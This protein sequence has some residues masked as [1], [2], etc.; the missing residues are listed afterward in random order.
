MTAKDS[1]KIS[2]NLASDRY[3]GMLAMGTSTG[4]LKIFSLKGYEQEIYDAHDHEINHVAFVPN[5]GLLI[6]IDISNLL[7]L[8]DMEDLDDCEV[9]CMVPK[10]NPQTYKVSCLYVPHFITNRPEN[11]RHVFVGLDQG[12]IK[13]F[14]L[15]TKMF[16]V[17]CITFS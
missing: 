8:W 4:I 5:Q 9:Q 11:H 14:D 2:S 15:Q 7:K 13:I 12:D 6:S 17:Y 3:Q 10:P 1:G 16:S